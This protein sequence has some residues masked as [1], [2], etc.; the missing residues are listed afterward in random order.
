M[1]TATG[2]SVVRTA[3]RAQLGEFL[4]TRRAKIS[5]SDVGLPPGP[6]RRT[7]GLRREEVA[8]LSGIGVTWYTWL[9]QGRPINASVQVLDAIARTLALDPTEKAHL[10]RLADVPTVPNIPGQTAMPPGIPSILEQ[11]NPLPAVLLNGC[12]DVL[13][14]NDAYAKLCP[15]FL[16]GERNVLRRVFLSPECCNP[17]ARSPQDLRRMVAY[18]RAAYV[19]H[20]DDPAW[21][22]LV[23]ELS[24]ASPVF[25]EMWASND[26]AVPANLVKIIRHPAI[27]SV[28]AHMTSMSLPTIEGAWMQIFTPVDDGE[29]AKLATLLAMPEQQR[30]DP[31]L[32]HLAQAHAS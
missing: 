3:R 19:K 13:A 31:I 17:Y 2:S 32:A 11:L 27:G 24:S 8:Q 4:K 30:H 26:V 18:L 5:P 20:L 12:Y 6:R 16:Q 25:A 15:G 14:H 22:S 10:Y 1:S 7:P 9:E 28:A 23:D 29:A 21:T